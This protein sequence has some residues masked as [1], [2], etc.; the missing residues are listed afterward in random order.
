MTQI[1]DRCTP[2]V[3]CVAHRYVSN[4]TDVD[5]VVQDT[6][7]SLVEHLQ[8]IRS[9]ASTHAWLVQV[10]THAAWRNRRTVARCAPDANLGEQAADDDTEELGLCHVWREQL[11]KPLADAVQE[12]RPDNRRLVELLAADDPPDYRTASKMLNRPIGSIGPTHQRAIEQ[13]RR[14]PSLAPFVDASQLA[15]AAR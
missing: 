12:L 14:Q 11:R 4:Q 13:L 7:L 1:V 5:D 10:T 6:W 8:S 3:R 2:M 15:T 9:P